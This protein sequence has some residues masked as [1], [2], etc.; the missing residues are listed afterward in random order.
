MAKDDTRSGA[1]AARGTGGAGA[2]A[3]PGPTKA[4]P[5]KA[6]PP[7]AE[8]QEIRLADPVELARAIASIAE[9]SQRIVAEFLQRRSGQPAAAIADPLN[10]GSAFF[11][12]TT[13]LMSNPARLVQAQLS[14]WQ[15]YMQLW[16]TTT[17]RFMGETA[18][19][20]IAPGVDDR[21]FK[22]QA[23][24]ENA[25]FDYIKQSYLLTA[26]WLQATVKDVEGLDD[27]TARKVDFYTRQ[28][29]D[30]IAPSNFVMTNPEVLRSTLETGGENLIN[31]LHN[32]L[33][34]L[35]RGQGKLS[36][37]MTDEQAF[38]VG[39]NIA[40]TPGKVVFQ[41]D[42][43]QL[44]Q[45]AP[46]TKEVG[47]RPLLVVPPW[48]NKFYIL[49]L[50][51]KNSFVKWAVEQ[52]H[53]VFVVSW[54]NPDAALAHKTF[55]DYMV[56]GILAALEAMRAATGERR[57][58]VIGY[59]LGGTL[60][61]A[62]LAYL[63]EAQDD[64]VASATFFTAMVDFKEA[65]ELSVFIDEEQLRHLESK[66]TADGYLDGRSMAT[67]FNMLRANDLIWSFVVNNY[68]LGKD[69]FPFDLL[70][71]NSDSTRMP[72]AMHSFYLRKM[73][74]E[75]KLAEPGGIA[76]KGVPIDLRKVALP[77]FI[78]ATREDHIAPWRS[79]Y[80][81]TRIYRGPV[82]FCLA[83]SGHIAGVVNPPAARKYGH[84]ALEGGANPP[85]P[86]EWLQQATQHPG[87]WWPRWH[88]FAKAHWDG[89][90]P[91][92]VPGDGQLAAIEDAPGSYV[93]VR[94]T[95]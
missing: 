7:E 17:K 39:R 71:W 50:R 91:A 4:E 26:R 86:E 83:A 32:L 57:A 82:T 78:L 60:L 41:T 59:C 74:Q 9:R 87:S 94:A 55:E 58:N 43:M 45:Y 13:R 63:A 14:L 10:I 80:A 15:S 12:M 16:Q 35:E 66:M 44:V 68:L 73:Y 21:R 53:T 36:I 67:T 95:A 18:E 19:P 11:E 49:D 62:T 1:G 30:A 5:P 84:W 52:G 51:E 81:A 24:E 64:R 2:G 46:L 29:V 76:L 88:D 85:T 8:P 33:D 34:D 27:R 56:E 79:T 65:G 61:A 77:T 20:V 89:M 40:V 47:K 93:K 92:R 37:K 90:V 69:P 22:D 25:V 38:E 48:I 70:Y 42:L 23:W 31:G 6:E 54:V 28:F 3:P 75:N 72:A